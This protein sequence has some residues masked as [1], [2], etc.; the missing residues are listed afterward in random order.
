[1]KYILII[2]TILSAIFAELVGLTHEGVPWSKFPHNLTKGGLFFMFLT[3]ILGIGSIYVIAQDEINH[4]AEK[5]ELNKKITQQASTINNLNSNVVNLEKDV[6]KYQHPIPDKF[7]ACIKFE[8]EKTAE[9][10]D[11]QVKHFTEFNSIYIEF[12]VHDMVGPK[13]FGVLSEELTVKELQKRGQLYVNKNSGKLNVSIMWLDLEIGEN[14]TR[15][16]SIYDLCDKDIEMNFIMNSENGWLRSTFNLKEFSLFTPTKNELKIKDIKII[17]G[18]A[19]V[20]TE[21]ECWI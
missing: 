21:S 18:S 10:R 19:R 8:F 11:S 17:D 15:Y 3:I 7:Q 9:E 20:K 13:I 2:L 16:Y 6:R 1:M 4:K 12:K 5:D 14:N